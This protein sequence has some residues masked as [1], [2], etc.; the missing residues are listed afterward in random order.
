MRKFQYIPKNK[1]IGNTENKAIVFANT[2]MKSE[3]DRFGNMAL[4]NDYNKILNDGCIY[5]PNFLCDKDDLLLFNKIKEEINDQE[6]VNWSK[7]LKYEN[8]EFSQTFKEIVDKM[9]IYFGVKVL[10]TRLNYYHDGTDWK[11][12]HHDSHAYGD[13]EENFT[14]GASFGA[15]R[16][17]LFLHKESESKF[18]FPQNNGD[19]F[20]FNKEVNQKFMHGVPKKTG[21]IGDRL[22]II[23]WGKKI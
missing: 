20:A 17:L 7:H 5:L 4:V 14:M 6:P 10:Q 21:K 22:S 1:K 11:P 13:K 19:V 12:L 18:T 3:F 9:A 2:I 8:P 15:S 16:E 23:A